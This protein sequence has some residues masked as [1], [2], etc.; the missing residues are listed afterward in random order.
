MA[1]RGADQADLWSSRGGR[2]AGNR[3]GERLA[4]IFVL[5]VVL[6]SP[7]MMGIFDRGPDVRVFG[8]PL[9]YAFLLGAWALLIA[10]IALATETRP[11]SRRRSGESSRPAPGSRGRT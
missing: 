4:A 3:T 10:L 8:I 6:F 7:L 11:T 5:G 1:K 9:L 2:R